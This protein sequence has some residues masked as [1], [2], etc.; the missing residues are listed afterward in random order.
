MCAEEGAVRWWEIRLM[1]AMI[2]GLV[3][4]ENQF[5]PPPEFLVG[6]NKV[7]LDMG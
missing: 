6:F 4:Q 1:V 7:K 2:L 5:T 3:L